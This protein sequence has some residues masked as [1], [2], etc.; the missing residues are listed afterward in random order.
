MYVVP[1][2]D[3]DFESASPR[4]GLNDVQRHAMTV[5]GKHRMVLV[6][7]PPG[8]GKAQMSAATIDAWAR[9]V[10]DNDIVIAAGPSNTATDNLL[11]R[12]A[13][14]EDRKYHIGRFGESKSIFDPKRVQYSL[15]AKAI[16]IAGKDAKKTRINQV[17]RQL[18]TDNQQPVIFTTYVKSAELNVTRPLFT[19]ADWA[20][21]A[22]EPT[23]AVLLA[24]AAEGGHI[25]IV[26]DEHQL[27][28]TVRDRRAEWDGLSCSLTARLNRE[29]KGLDHVIML[30][31]QY[32]M[33]PDIQSFPNTQYYDRALLCGLTQALESIDGIPWP[34]M[35]RRVVRPGSGHTGDFKC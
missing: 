34:T 3:W 25:M 17:V 35:T 28:P 8:T 22:M 9:N 18:I 33:H 15:T 4:A 32:R 19:L 31:I 2:S 7:G 20:G 30:V 27:A 14:L 10:N 13:A 16:R 26:G 11:H 12:S 29:H 5:T 24:N 1:P 6:R 21:Q 23:T